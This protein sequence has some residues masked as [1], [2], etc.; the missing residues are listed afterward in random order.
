MGVPEMFESTETAMTTS[1]PQ[2]VVTH[3]GGT[4]SQPRLHRPRAPYPDA[5]RAYAARHP[6]RCHVRGPKGGAGADAELRE[7]L[8]KPARE[9]DVPLIIEGIDIGAGP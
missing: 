5:R 8:G 6:G 2:G 4:Q 9:A 1:S 3:R 7:L